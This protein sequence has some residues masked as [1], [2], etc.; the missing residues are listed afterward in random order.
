[1]LSPCDMLTYFPSNCANARSG[2]LRLLCKL[3]GGNMTES[4]LYVTHVYQT[5]LMHSA[6]H[7]NVEHDEI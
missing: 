3:F 5:Y 1:M 4:L 6:G 7:S 2:K